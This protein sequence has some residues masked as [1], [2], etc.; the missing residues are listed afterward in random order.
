MWSRENIPLLIMSLLSAAILF[1]FALSG[2]TTFSA[3][4]QLDGCGWSEQAAIAPIWPR[5][6]NFQQVLWNPAFPPS[7]PGRP[8][9]RIGCTK[10]NMTGIG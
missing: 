3:P 7:P 8:P 5:A 1:F 4:R 2:S 10:S 9:A 6:G